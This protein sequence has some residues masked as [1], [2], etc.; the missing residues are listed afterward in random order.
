MHVIAL[1]GSP[2]EHGNTFQA[3]KLVTDELGKEGITTEIIHVG[4]KANEGCR[5]CGSC[6]KTGA[7]IITTDSVNETAEKIGR[8]DGLIIGSPVQYASIAGSLKNYLDRMFFSAGRRVMRH[9][10][11]AAVVAVRRTGGMSAFHDLNSYFLIAEAIVPAANYWN[12]IHGHKPGEIQG[13]TEG[14]QIMRVL[15]RNMGWVMKLIEHGKGTVAEPECEQKQM[16]NFI[17]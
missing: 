12:V 10:V 3:I 17:H 11:A 2:K 5:A 1:N 8:A 13:D 15:G 6:A 14:V 4:N 9:K 16:M 7:C